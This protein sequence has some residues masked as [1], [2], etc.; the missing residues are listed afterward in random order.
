MF[1]LMKRA[2]FEGSNINFRD[3]IFG[4]LDVIG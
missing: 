1:K 2:D 3:V 4:A